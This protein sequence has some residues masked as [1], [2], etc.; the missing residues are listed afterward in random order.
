METTSF[1]LSVVDYQGP[2][3]WTWRLTGANGELGHQ[4]QLDTACD[5]YRAFQE[6]SGNGAGASWK[7]YDEARSGTDLDALGDW[8]GNQLLGPLGPAV[9]Q[10]KPAVVT[11]ELPV[12]AACLAILPWELVRVNGTPLP[13]HSV[14]M[15]TADV[16]QHNQFPFASYDS[17]NKALRFLAVF[18]A[19][20]ED[21]GLNQRSERHALDEMLATLSATKEVAI[22]FRALQ[23][24]VTSGQLSDALND[25]ESWDV[26]HVSG[27]ADTGLL[28]FWP[29]WQPQEQVEP[30]GLASLLNLK[31]V[32]PRLL[33]ISASVSAAAAR[34]RGLGLPGYA[35]AL[36][37][38]AWPSR[39]PD[40][41]REIASTLGCAV[42]TFRFPV[43]DN[44]ACAY[45]CRLYGLLIGR[46]LDLPR[47]MVSA[48]QELRADWS[49][50]PLAAPTFYGSRAADLKLTA[51]PRPA[52][53][54]PANGLGTASLRGAPAESFVGRD[55]VMR[56]A[57]AALANNSK[58]SGVMLY[59]MPGIGKTSC[60]RELAFTRDALDPD[61]KFPRIV[62][63]QI[64]SEAR[65]NVQ[66]AL[67]SFMKE[68]RDIIGDIF[69]KPYVIDDED[70]LRA[71]LPIITEIF[72]KMRVLVLLE[73]V[74]TVIDGNGRWRGRWGEVISALCGHSK[75]LGRV[76]LTS[77]RLPVPPL[78][79]IVVLP[80]G[81]LGW[82]ESVQLALELN[83]LRSLFAAT[84]SDE[85]RER[86][87]KLLI[88]SR[89]HPKLIEL[90]NAAAD[91]QARSESMLAA[92]DSWPPPAPAYPGA[93]PVRMY[94]EEEYVTLLESWTAVIV[95]S[96]EPAARALFQVLCCLSEEDRTMQMLKA[97]WSRLC[98]QIFQQGCGQPLIDLLAVLHRLGLVTPGLNA[99]G[100]LI[101]VR[102]HPV[103]VE[104]GRREAEQSPG[105]T[106]PGIRRLVDTQLAGYWTDRAA[107]GDAGAS[108]REA[109]YRLR[110]TDAETTDSAEEA[111]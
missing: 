97:N 19:L 70:Q 101:A 109:A 8:L 110:L 14:A 60:A 49:R 57:S 65:E 90:A 29:D 6:L 35:D 51:P 39:G 75:G 91:H 33:T 24:D 4:V 45:F 1:R 88:A 82:N 84:A 40:A 86:A 55:E 69:P 76:L 85:E 64:D 93:I 63:Y 83:P 92:V 11:V 50:V 71:A 5:E 66:T 38:Q 72:R 18:P 100:E 7:M 77:R 78:P 10:R 111:K 107:E 37:G 89:G 9:I 16:Q 96:L 52:A 41:A 44:F 105:G 87:R 98:D 43:A 23:Y 74:E 17:A 106:E 73:N 15:V 62:S 26:V 80:V 79:G 31:S 21:L 56:K 47:A 30:Q 2:A 59:G 68:L 104:Q 25:D 61:N 67:H 58:C 13:M 94:S 36:L 103:L 108:G 102:V 46:Q 32:R 20:R 53:G 99:S 95:T 48:W 3:S 22:D 81:V 54:T 34:A 42:G 12:S 28:E 27:Y